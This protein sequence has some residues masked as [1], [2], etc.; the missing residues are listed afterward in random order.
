M[1]VHSLSLAVACL[2]AL[3]ATAEAQSNAPSSRLPS[4][5]PT[6]RKPNRH[7]EIMA[8]TQNDL[9]K[10]AGDEWLSY[11]GDYTGRHFST[12]GQI[13]T[14]NVAKLTR[15]W[16]SNV[17][18]PDTHDGRIASGLLMR[19]GVIFYT[20]DIDAYAIDARTGRQI[21]HYVAEMSDGTSNRGFG[22]EGD[23]LFVFYNGGLVALQAATGKEIWTK[24]VG[25]M[26]PM[27]PLV[28][29][30]H[31]YVVTGGDI[32]DMR[33][34]IES[35]NAKS[36][37][38]EWVFYTVPREGEPGFNTWISEEAAARGNGS[39]WQTPT[40]DPETNLL[41][42]GTGNPTPIK[43]GRVR[44]GDN[45]FTDCVV[46]LDADTGKMAW[47]F[48]AT[49]HD[50]HDWDNNQ[51][52]TLADVTL[53]GK[54]RKILTWVSRNGFQFTLDRTTGENLLTSKVTDEVNWAMSQIRSN[55]TP[56]KNENKAPS[57]GGSLVSPDSSGM[58][59]WQAQSYS[60]VTGLHYANVLNSHS[61]F[62]W[63]GE[64]FLGDTRA[65]LRASDPLTG[66]VVWQHD[67][68]QLPVGSYVHNSSVLSTAGGLL[69]TGDISGNFVAFDG[70]TG[71]I[72]WHDELP[73]NS[74]VTGIPITYR[75][76]GHQYV[77]T[78]AGANLVAYI[79][80]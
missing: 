58:T 60:P 37:E 6:M 57:R 34:S 18:R 76:G 35:R 75:L 48:Q 23:R 49:P 27:A 21:W 19:S 11:H 38:R 53:A 59:N 10:P 43:D 69:F 70:G 26:T 28:V 22:I 47:Y 79:L 1:T 4:T 17:D 40:Y 29:R 72:L 74:L 54:R 16:M 52:M 14:G 73:N 63:S 41:L 78:P 51:T 32:A 67:Y 9:L 42:V 39:P 31:V 12:L 8:V 50:D 24:K 25:P 80:P 15:A 7:A 68:P 36:G 55:G 46:A 13:T 2:A 65:S 77:V 64:S 20:S 33:G 44:P 3:A 66:K 61:V 62:Y 5:A 71:K 56:E 30:E 45:L